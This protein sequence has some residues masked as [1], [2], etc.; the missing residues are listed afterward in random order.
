MPP[1]STI[2]SICLRIPFVLSESLLYLSGR[3][4]AAQ[5]RR[6]R[7]EVRSQAR[8]YPLTF[9]CLALETPQPWQASQGRGL[10]GPTAR[11]ARIAASGK[12][13][14]GGILGKQFLYA[15]GV[16]IFRSARPIIFFNTK[17]Y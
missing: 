6:P 3:P 15:T 8:R 4:P 1:L 16:E 10:R 12:A 7:R 2:A 11:S 14:Y 5:R 9:L 17:Y 13:K